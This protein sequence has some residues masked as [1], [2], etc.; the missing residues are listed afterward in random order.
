VSVVG[1]HLY[2]IGGAGGAGALDSVEQAN[3][4]ADGSLSGFAPTA[5]LRLVSPRRGHTAFVA[6]N[7]LYVVGGSN[8]ETLDSVER[9]QIDTAGALGPLAQLPD[10]RLAMSRRDH[11]MVVVGNGVYVIGGS[12]G[13]PMA[14][15]ERAT[16]KADGLLENFELVPDVQLATARY[17]HT[18]TVIGDSVF[19]VGGTGPSGVIGDVE[20]SRIGSDGRLGPFTSVPGIS[21]S[22]ARWGILRQRLAEFSISQVALVQMES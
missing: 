9:A 14:S 16:I 4:N 1:S 18:A 11:A 6:S 13:S 12:N 22:A 10:V 7:Y 21:L 3:I 20:R 15:L 2:V 5:G 19:V 8:T 17:G